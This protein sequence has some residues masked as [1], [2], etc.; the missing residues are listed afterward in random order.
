M[1]SLSQISILVCHLLIALCVSASFAQQNLLDLLPDRQ[2]EWR[3]IITEADSNIDVSTS[4]LLLEPNGRLRAT[5][6]YR[7]SKQENAFE[8]PGAKYKTRL[9]TLQFDTRENTYRVIETTLLDSSEKVVYASGLHMTRDW[10]P[11]RGR[12]AGR[13]YQT[14]VA[15]P[16]LGAWTV[17]AAHYP[18]GTVPRSNNEHPTTTPL[19]RSR[20]DTRVDQFEVGRNA[21]STPSYESASFRDDEFVKWTGFTLKDMGFSTNNVD[22]IKI[23]CESPGRSSE[24]HLL[25]LASVDRAKLLSGGVVLDLEK[26]EY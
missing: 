21:C 15:L 20:V 24:I 10:K 12:T 14:A 3:R 2:K 6:R 4:S 7:L 16:P 1:R 8:K 25:L 13:F 23:K 19:I 18:D 5:F 17:V 11:I 9:E 22:A 26:L